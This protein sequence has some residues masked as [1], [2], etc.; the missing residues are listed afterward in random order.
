VAGASEDGVAV[1]RVESAFRSG[2]SV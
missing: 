2:S 1:V